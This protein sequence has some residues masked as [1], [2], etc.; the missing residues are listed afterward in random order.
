LDD[1]LAALLHALEERRLLDTALI[2]F[3]AATARSSATT[4]RAATA[5]RSTR[6]CCTCRCGSTCPAR[7]PGPE[8]KPVDAAEAAGLRAEL[9]GLLAELGS[10]AAPAP[11]QPLAPEL[12]EQLQALG[13]LPT[14]GR[15]PP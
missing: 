13:Y 6:S 9:A 15:K 14:P 7:R 11:T 8:R 2:V 12:R 5:T 3:V 10:D 4:A 1:A